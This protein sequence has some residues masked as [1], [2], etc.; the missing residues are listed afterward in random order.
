VVLDTGRARAMAA[1]YLAGYSTSLSA[2]VAA[3]PEQLVVQVSRDVSTSFV[4]LVGISTV[5]IAASATGEPQ[6]GIERGSR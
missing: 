2:S 4:R 5:R 6:H 1:E 3:E